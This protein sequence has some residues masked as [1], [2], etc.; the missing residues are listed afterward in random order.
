[1]RALAI[2][3]GEVHCGIAV[4]KSGRAAWSTCTVDQPTLFDTVRD[5]LVRRATDVVVCEEYRLYPWLLQQQGFSPVTTVEAI[6]VVRYLCVQHAMRFV[7]QPATIKKPTF[8]IIKKRGI[9][10]IGK[11]QHER[12]AEAHAWHFYLN[13]GH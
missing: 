10:L 4:F 2:D 8:G 9:A 7:L 12:D 1:M 13:G 11:T 6:G 3:P 5:A